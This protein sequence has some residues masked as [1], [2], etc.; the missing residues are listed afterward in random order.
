MSSILDT[1]YYQL[2]TKGRALL[3]Q[4]WT[5]WKKFF[6][7]NDEQGMDILVSACE[8]RANN[9]DEI[10]MGVSWCCNV[11][12]NNTSMPQGRKWIN[13][14]KDTNNEAF[15]VQMGYST[16]I[17]SDDQVPEDMKYVSKS[18]NIVGK[19]KSEYRRKPNLIKIKDRHTIYTLIDKLINNSIKF[20]EEII[21]STTLDE[22]KQFKL[23]LLP[24]DDIRVRL[25]KSLQPVDPSFKTLTLETF[26]QPKNSYRL[27]SKGFNK[28]K[29]E[30]GEFVELDIGAAFPTQIIANSKSPLKK[31]LIST[32]GVVVRSQIE[33]EVSD[34]YSRT[35]KQINTIYT[36][37]FTKEECL[38]NIKSTMTLR[39]MS[40]IISSLYDNTTDGWIRSNK[41]AT[42][43]KNISPTY[44]TF[45]TI[46]E[47]YQN[48]NKVKGEKIGTT[49][50]R[51]LSKG[52]ARA[53]TVIADY[54]S[55]K[56]ISGHYSFDGFKITSNDSLKI[57]IMELER[58][59]KEKTGVNFSLKLKNNSASLSDQI[60][61]MFEQLA[62]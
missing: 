20:G 12:G 16:K 14:N 54:L 57:N 31:E 8:A 10:W 35:D 29:S 4:D 21:P 19:E 48:S 1:I 44:S 50:H 22:Q 34:W 5:E 49:M 55:T 62:A 15:N 46:C 41:F 7:C 47:V 24:I 40:P 37:D 32:N 39:T 58:L 3:P 56:E 28:P 43:L 17:Y 59:V 18:Y 30:M 51:E 25:F 60:D 26:I 53:M 27:Y 33:A 52:E 38:Q 61:S 13:S 6:N 2:P 11:E 9:S 45:D 42:F 36:S 23:S